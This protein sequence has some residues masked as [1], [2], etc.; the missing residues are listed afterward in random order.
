[1]KQKPYLS[2]PMGR[3][4][5]RGVNLAEA[6]LHDPDLSEAYLLHETGEGFI[7]PRRLA[8]RE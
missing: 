5:L 6:D 1:M 2:Q 8:Q 4:D 3:A 7:T